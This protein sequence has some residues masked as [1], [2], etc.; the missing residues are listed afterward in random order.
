MKDRTIP[1]DNLIIKKPIPN[2]DIVNDRSSDEFVNRNLMSL[3]SDDLM[4][5]RPMGEMLI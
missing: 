2:D 3:P 5:D 4:N 1:N